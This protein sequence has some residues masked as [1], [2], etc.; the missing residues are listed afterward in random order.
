M[1]SYFNRRKFLIF[2]LLVVLGGCAKPSL[3]LEKTTP[4]IIFFSTKDFRF[5]DA[6]LIKS[7]SNGDISLEIFNAGHLLLEFLVFKNRICLNQQCYA[8]NTITRKLFGNDGLLEL[9]FKAILEGKEILGGKNK[10]VFNEGYEQ[11][12]NDINYQIT[13]QVTAQMISFKELN[14]GFTLIISGI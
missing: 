10:V 14:S 4:K 5:Y 9:D 8:K 2:L 7:Y 6:G 13:Y 1:V 11:R 3:S 12:I